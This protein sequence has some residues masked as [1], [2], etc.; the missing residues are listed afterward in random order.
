M[1]EIEIELDMLVV[2]IAWA[3]H[4]SIVL[5]IILIFVGS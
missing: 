5:F 4:V 1:Q 3:M 2:F